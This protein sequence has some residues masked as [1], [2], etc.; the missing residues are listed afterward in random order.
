MPMAVHDSISKTPA[1]IYLGSKF[2]TFFQR[3][4][5]VSDSEDEL[6]GED[7]YKLVRDD[8]VQINKAQKR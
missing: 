3:L 2:I 1:D 4:V 7:V 6:L 5:M 8:R